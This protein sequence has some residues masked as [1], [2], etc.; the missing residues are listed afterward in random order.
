MAK[1][2]AQRGKGGQRQTRPAPRRG[3]RGGGSGMPW[4]LGAVLGLSIGLAVAVFVY[5]FVR[6]AQPLPGHKSISAAAPA[7]S[8]DAGN[9]DAESPAQRNKAALSGK[10]NVV[11]LPPKVKTRFTFYELLPSQEVV[12]PREQVQTATGK[13]GAADTGL[14]VIQVASYRTQPDAD[15]LKAKL[16]LLGVESRI[17]KVTIDN[18]DT[19]YRVRVGPEKNLGAVHTIV[20]RLEE[21]G[22]HQAMVVKVK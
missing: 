7:S 21:N 4:W 8:N 18:S 2:Y 10:Q 12:V 5:I 11:K 16:A 13:A 17:E 9:D 22:I 6:P 15:G 14:Y 1:D 3:G 19:Y 20:A